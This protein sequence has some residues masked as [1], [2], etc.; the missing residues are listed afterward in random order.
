MKFS[1]VGFAAIAIGTQAALVAAACDCAND[2]TDC[3]TK[4]GKL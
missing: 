2:D 3:L 4:C 1:F